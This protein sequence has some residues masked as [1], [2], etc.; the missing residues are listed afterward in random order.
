M[1]TITRRQFVKGMVFGGAAMAGAMSMPGALH[2]AYA[3]KPKLTMAIWNHWVPGATDVHTKIINGWAKENKV[4]VRIDLIGPS[5][6]A[7]RTIASAEYR[8][9][10]GHDIMALS[11]FVSIAFKKKLEPLNDVADSI[12]KKYGKFD[13]LATYLN[14]QDGVWFSI[15]NPMGSFSK[16]P[17]SRIDLFK[18]HAGID[19]VDVFPPDESKRDP[20]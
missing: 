11:T 18:K 16:P 4:D 15:P 6:A 8:A 13:D 1:A 14:Y 10:T 19:V 2:K 9:E 3:Q 20:K 5:G 17:V 7:I 12:E